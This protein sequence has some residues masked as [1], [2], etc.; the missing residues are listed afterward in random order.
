[1]VI[2]F[3]NTKESWCQKGR[4]GSLYLLRCHPCCQSSLFHSS[5]LEHIRPESRCCAF[6]DRKRILRFH[7]NDVSGKRVFWPRGL[8]VSRYLFTCIDTGELISWLLGKVTPWEVCTSWFPHC[9]TSI[10][11]NNWYFTEFYR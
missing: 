8:S 10:L 11:K 6:V 3:M 7:S 4:I 2:P 9:Y 1:M 5:L